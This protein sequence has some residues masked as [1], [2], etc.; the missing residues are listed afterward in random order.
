MRHQK[1]QFICLLFLAFGMAGLRAQEAQPAA[2]GEA[3]GSGGSVSYSVG[4]VVYSTVSGSS[5]SSNQG[6][7]QPYE[8]VVETALDEAKGI[9]LKVL[10]YPNPVQDFLVLKIGNNLISD[11]NSALN[12]LSYQ[13]YDMN[14]SLL[15]RAGVTASETRISMNRFIPA[16]YFLKVLR[17]EREIK[18]FKIIKH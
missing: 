15:K 12:D 9:E 17:G 8:I 13:L 10:A 6:I 4:Q 2:G 16:F 11:R 1:I 18:T 3:S 14:G 7:Q 5:G